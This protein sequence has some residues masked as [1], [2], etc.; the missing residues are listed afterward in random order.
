MDIN[1]E[2]K[3]EFDLFCNVFQDD[4]IDEKALKVTGQTR[5]QI[6]TF[7]DPIVVKNQ[8]VKIFNKY[9]NKFDKNDK[10]VFAGY[11]SRSFDFPL[12]YNWYAKKCK[13]GF[14]GS[15]IDFQRKFDI[16]A[17]IENMQVLGRLPIHKNKLADACKF[18]GV[19]LENAHDGMSDI[20][21]TRDLYYK[22]KE[23]I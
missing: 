4:L 10:F 7:E 17:L 13:E 1:G 8:L 3:E 15:Y 16:L 5:E 6:A 11:N 12:F 19:E 9:I 22:I 2:I 20:R 18:Y 21:A 14:L 23:M